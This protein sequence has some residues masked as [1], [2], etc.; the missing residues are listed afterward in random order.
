MSVN[1]MR[2]T[3]GD[4]VYQELLSAIYDGR[5]EPGQRLNDI[6]LAEELGISRTPVR[7]ALQK[8]KAA[9][10][11][12][13]EPNRFT[14]VAVVTPEQVRQHLVVWVALMHALVDEVGQSVPKNVTRRMETQHSRFVRELHELGGMGTGDE[15]LARRVAKSRGLATA[16]FDFF[17]SLVGLSSNAPLRV[18]LETAQHVVRLGSLSLSDW[19]DVVGLERVQSRLL[20]A[21]TAGDLAASHAAIAN[22]LELVVPGAATTTREH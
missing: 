16:N 17:T 5:L 11:V 14:R 7:E 4:S 18:A 22:L 12:E 6:A 21:L 3:V 15:L 1:A 10:M 19:V 2:V 20:E 9:G 13:S 8:L